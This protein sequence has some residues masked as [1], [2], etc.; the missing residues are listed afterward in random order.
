MFPI[1]CIVLETGIFLFVGCC[2]GCLRALKDGCSCI[3][4]IGGGGANEL[5]FLIPPIIGADGGGANLLIGGGGANL[6][7]CGAAAELFV[8]GALTSVEF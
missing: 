4:C 3:V 6:L 8:L 7:V 5:L 2:C 1:D